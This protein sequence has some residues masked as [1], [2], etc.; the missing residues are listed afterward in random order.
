MQ[1][2]CE[3]VKPSISVIGLVAYCA[4]PPNMVFVRVPNERARWMI[5]HR[6]V[7][8]VACAWCKA[9]AGEP[10]K[11]RNRY[12]VGTHC[13]RRDAHKDMKWRLKTDGNNLPQHKPHLSTADITAAAEKL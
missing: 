12:S 4:L 10:C 5:T 9:V 11:T 1:I 3:P 8:D 13:A 7:V 6:C 2:E